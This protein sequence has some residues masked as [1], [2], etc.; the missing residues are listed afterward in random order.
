MT[1]TRVG[2]CFGAGSVIVV[3]LTDFPSSAA[4]GSKVLVVVLVGAIA[5]AQGKL[6]YWTSLVSECVEEWVVVQKKERETILAMI[7]IMAMAYC[8]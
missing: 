2:I 8:L 1:G 4:S 7:C 3:L 6:W 5:S